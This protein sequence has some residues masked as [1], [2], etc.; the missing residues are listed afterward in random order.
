MGRWSSIA[1]N[2]QKLHMTV[3][4]GAGYNAVSSQNQIT[5]LFFKTS[6][7]TSSQAGSTG[8]FFADGFSV[9][10]GETVNAPSVFRVV[11][12]DA[13]TFDFYASFG[14]FTGN[15]FYVLTTAS[16]TWTHSGTL[17]SPTG[18]YID[19]TPNTLLHAGNFMSYAL[20]LTGGTIT[21]QLSITSS[22]DPAILLSG[23]VED[24]STH[25]YTSIGGIG[26][27]RIQ[28]DGIFKSLGIEVRSGSNVNAGSAVF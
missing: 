6:N 26:K 18:N 21:G 25:L 12:V 16:G 20:P 23:G 14:A 13:N 19:I 22:T 4:A 17:A 28:R 10:V 7:G 15:S 27:V 9:R 5:Q 2:G 8:A 24:S 3:V 11:Q 1:Q